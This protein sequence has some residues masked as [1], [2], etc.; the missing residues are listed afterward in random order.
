MH[1]NLRG[2]RV[3]ILATDGVE[4]VELEKP[5]QA[6]DRAGATT[7]IIA[8]R[9]PEIQGYH[10]HDRGDRLPVDMELDMVK[11]SDFDALLLPG[12]ALNPDQLRMLPAA[13]E[14]V[15]GFV[16]A[17]KPVAAICHGA[18]TLVEAGVVRGRTMTSW[19][20]IKTDLENAGARWVDEEVVVDGE[21]VTSRKPDDLPAFCDKM[22]EAFAKTEISAVAAE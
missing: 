21:W 3:A 6:L 4:Q 1:H 14:F 8:P 2:T 12:G 22:V 11:V 9:G 13:V 10:H 16:E 7:L 18:W 17:G 5:R 15:R 19:P 20:S